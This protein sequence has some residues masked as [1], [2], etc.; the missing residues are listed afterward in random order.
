M[1][2]LQFSEYIF[3][4]K[5]IIKKNLKQKK[6]IMM[7]KFNS[8]LKI[9]LNYIFILIKIKSNLNIFFFFLKMKVIKKFRIWY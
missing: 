8:N 2:Y 6:I 1:S 5:N 7:I 3:V 4:K 9:L